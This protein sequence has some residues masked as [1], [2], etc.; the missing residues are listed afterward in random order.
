MTGEPVSM[1]PKAGTIVGA[2][3]EE[4]HDWHQARPAGQS[5]EASLPTMGTLSSSG[6]GYLGT[7]ARPIEMG[8][9]PRSRGEPTGPRHT[10]SADTLLAVGRRSQ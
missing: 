2:S 7:D 6:S 9:S 8:S 4:A 10:Y 5:G 1:D 3:G